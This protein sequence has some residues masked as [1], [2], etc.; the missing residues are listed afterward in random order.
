[1]EKEWMRVVLGGEER[2]NE[3]IIKEFIFL[4]KI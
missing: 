2:G 4:E 3:R 1:M